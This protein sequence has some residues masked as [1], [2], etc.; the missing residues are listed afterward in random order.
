M[1]T[2]NEVTVFY[3]KKFRPPFSVKKAAEKILAG[4]KKKSAEINIIFT[5]SRFMKSINAAYR[6]KNRETD[7]IS[8]E[9]QGKGKNCAG[10]DIFICIDKARENAK[11]YGA[12]FKEEL[13]RLVAHGVLHALGYDHEKTGA[14]RKKMLYKQNRYI[15]AIM[16][17]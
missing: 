15:K 5:G 16:K 12:T 7:V 10:G 8:F 2:R 14:G 1:K 17:N 9:I 6:L 4:E 3:R 11:E 13:A